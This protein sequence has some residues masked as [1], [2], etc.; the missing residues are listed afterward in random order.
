MVGAAWRWRGGPMGCW[1]VCGAFVPRL[2]EASQKAEG[3]DLVRGLRTRDL[4]DLAV[5]IEARK[6]RL[7]ELRV[8]W[9]GRGGARPSRGFK[10]FECFRL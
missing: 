2:L 6:R 7:A 1:G 8:G 3:A 4:A 9:S 5:S 10:R